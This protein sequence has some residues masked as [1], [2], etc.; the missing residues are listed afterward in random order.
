VVVYR[1]SL[2]L[3]VV[4]LMW[5]QQQLLLEVESFLAKTWEGADDILKQGTILLHFTWGIKLHLYRVLSQGN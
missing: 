4:V 5:L 3:L 1:L 2:H